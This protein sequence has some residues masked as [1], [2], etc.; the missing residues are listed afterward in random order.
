VVEEQGEEPTTILDNVIGQEAPLET[1]EVPW[2]MAL[3]GAIELSGIEA[4]MATEELQWL[5]DDD[6]STM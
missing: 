1:P 3:V 2:N 6:E 5:G 4:L